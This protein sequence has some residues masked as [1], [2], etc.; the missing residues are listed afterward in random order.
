MSDLAQLIDAGLAAGVI[1]K[2]GGGWL[3]FGDQKL[4]QGDDKAAA[5]LAS[6]PE[7]AAQIG[8]AVEAKAG[9]PKEAAPMRESDASEKVSKSETRDFAV[10]S[11]VLH[12][13]EHYAIGEPI[14]ITQKQFDALKSCGAVE[15]N[16]SDGK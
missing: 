8:A 13:G 6:K 16:W 3:S 11:A 10:I 12:D 14:T 1:S 15:G 2:G 4:G 7:L 9:V 5:M